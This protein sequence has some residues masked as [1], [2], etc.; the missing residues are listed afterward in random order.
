MKESPLLSKSCKCPACEREGL[1]RM[2]NPRL[3]SVTGRES[4]RHVT[5]YRWING[6]ETDVLPHHYRIWQ[7]PHCLFADFPESFLGG[8]DAHRELLRSALRDISVE[9]HMILMSLRELVPAGDLDATG[10]IAIHLACLLLSTLVPKDRRDHGRLGHIALRL[11]WLFREQGADTQP[12]LKAASRALTG[13]A[14]A[15]E[16]MGRLM[17]EAG[18]ALGD[19]ENLGAQRSRELDLPATSAGNPY[20]SVATLMGIRLKALHYQVSSLQMA[21]LQDQQGRMVPPP[22]VAKASGTGLGKALADLELLWPGLPQDEGKALQMALE[23]MEFSYLHEEGS[24]GEDQSTV[25][26]GL[27][28]EI[29]IRLQEYERAVDWTSL[30]SRHAFD[31]VADLKTRIGVGKANG[32]LSAYDE[33]VINRKIEALGLT[34]QRAGGRRREVL[35]LMLERDRE[36]IDAVLAGCASQAKEERLKALAAEGIHEALLPLVSRELATSAPAR[37][38][39]LRALAGGA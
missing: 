14:E 25:Q 30:I 9:K 24:G 32:T 39:G 31:E 2:A 26:A 13:L 38:R 19:I 16:R 15:A 4:D 35:E 22:A 20:L 1:F 23:A 6:I 21:L 28:L 11:A 12:K 5:G 18:E 33:T 29:L 17:A 36:R 34:Q 10:A 7:C 37:K 27:V 3:F 8:G